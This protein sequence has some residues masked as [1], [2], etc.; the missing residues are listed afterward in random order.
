MSLGINGSGEVREPSSLGAVNSEKLRSEDVTTQLVYARI[1]KIQSYTIDSCCNTP[2][3]N[4]STRPK[5]DI[6][7]VLEKRALIMNKTLP[8][9]EELKQALKTER[10]GKAYTYAKEV[11]THAIYIEQ[12]FERISGTLEQIRDHLPQEKAISSEIL[13]D[14]SDKIKGTPLEEMEASDI[15]GVIE[16]QNQKYENL[17]KVGVLTK[18]FGNEKVLDGL[19]R[20][21]KR[22]DAVLTTFIT[23]SNSNTKSQTPEV[24]SNQGDNRIKPSSR[25]YTRTSSGLK[26]EKKKTSVGASD[27]N[28]TDGSPSPAVNMKMNTKIA[29]RMTT[30]ELDEKALMAKKEAVKLKE[31]GIKEEGDQ[32]IRGG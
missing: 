4:A 17:E 25:P 24:D 30:K 8:I 16:E 12:K 23:S 7:D 9:I 27:K 15:K 18:R 29:E 28:V 22:L 2:R 31:K 5:I 3:L 26:E 13:S 10:G 19:E 6:F 32:K 21:L 1:M 11:I 14:F 20:E